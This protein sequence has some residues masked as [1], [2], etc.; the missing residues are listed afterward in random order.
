MLRIA[1]GLTLLYCAGHTLGMPWTPS[2]R[3]QDIAVLEAMKTDRFDDAGSTRTYWD[4][5]F[6]FGL[7][8]TGYLALQAVA[9]WQLAPLA[10]NAAMEVRPIVAVFFIA[11]VAN[12]IVVWMYFFV[13]PLVFAVAIAICLAL[14][15][16]F[17]RPAGQP[18][19][20]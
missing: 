18:K 20:G 7:A 12:A 19:P 16:L 1:A 3:P 11:F 8:I 17:A 4:F 13:I 15:F 10:K 9:L 6:G 5:Y 2:I 14:A